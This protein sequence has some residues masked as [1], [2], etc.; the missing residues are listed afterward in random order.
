[1]TPL[2]MAVISG[3]YRIVKKLLIRGCN[4]NISSL[5]N[6]MPLDLAYENDYKN[7]IDM[8]EDKSSIS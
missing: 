3:N 6:K 2:H 4:R 8:I 1:M 5:T 7:I